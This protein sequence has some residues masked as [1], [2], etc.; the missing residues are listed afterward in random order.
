M[1][2]V[3]LKIFITV[4]DILNGSLFEECYLASDSLL[5]PYLK[6]AQ[7]MNSNTI[8]SPKKGNWTKLVNWLIYAWKFV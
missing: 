6:G 3:F 7:N 5:N 4:K 2:N 8:Q 1:T